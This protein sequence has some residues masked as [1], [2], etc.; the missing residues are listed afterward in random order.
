[1]LWQPARRRVD[2]DVA[3]GR[4]YGEALAH[5]T[6]AVIAEQLKHIAIPRRFSVPMR[7]IWELQR[8][9]EYRTGSRAFRMLEHP[10][11]RAAYDLLVLCADTGGADP[12][13]AQWWTQFQQT[14]EHGRKQM[15]AALA[16]TPSTR[17]SKHRRRRAGRGRGQAGEAPVLG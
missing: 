15:V 13:L 12:A 16:P 5:A 2:L 7:E 10:R 4:P 8:R 14:D 3:R 9:L 17:R 1:M 6:D 11:F